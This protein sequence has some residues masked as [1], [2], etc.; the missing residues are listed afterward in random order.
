MEQ[1]ADELIFRVL[2]IH[3][4]LMVIALLV[5]RLSKLLAHFTSTRVVIECHVFYVVA[6]YFD[7]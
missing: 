3:K 7:I 6:F 5:V 1:V 2:L 4:P